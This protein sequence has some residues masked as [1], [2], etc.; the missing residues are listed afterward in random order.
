MN[1]RCD[2]VQNKQDIQNFSEFDRAI[3]QGSITVF[4]E[5]KASPFGS[6]SNLIE[7]KVLLPAK[8]SSNLLD[9]IEACIDVFS[10]ERGLGTTEVVE[11]GTAG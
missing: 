10:A 1:S 5:I 8:W 3:G 4:A 11:E 7:L 2:R 6:E 9:K